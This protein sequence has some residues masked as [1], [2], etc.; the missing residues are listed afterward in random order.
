MDVVKLNWLQ[1]IALE[2]IYSM[3]V[4]LL[5]TLR[6]E[7]SEKTL[8][9]LEEAQALESGQV[10]QK[11]AFLL[12]WHNRLLLMFFIFLHFKKRFPESAVMVSANKDGDLFSALLQRVGCRIIRGSA[13][14]KSLQ[15]L[16]GIH[17]NLKSGKLVMYAADGPTGPLYQFKPG[18]VFLSQKY[19]VPIHLVHIEAAPSIRFST[20]DRLILPMPFAKIV[21]KHTTVSA[22]SFSLTSSSESAL[23]SKETLQG[24]VE[25]LT[26]HMQKLTDSR[27][28]WIWLCELKNRRR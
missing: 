26:Q 21:L 3:A 1:R 5:S 7:V 15:A 20:W 9:F 2:L 6:I 16:K 17:K 22:K 28:D 12:F 27:E 10:E 24:S 13:N 8:A 23:Q 4:L 14:K 18:A 11:S 19:Q 25:I